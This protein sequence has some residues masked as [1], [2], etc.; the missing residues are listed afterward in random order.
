MPTKSTVYSKTK[1]ATADTAF[2]VE[3]SGSPEGETILSSINI[4]CYTN[5]CYYGTLAGQY[6]IIQAN[7]VVW[8]EGHIKVSDLW[9]KNYTAGSN[10][11]VVISGLVK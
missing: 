11:V 1:T 7:A 2:Q 4:H 6:G 10:T 3:P 9:F 8:F 5:P